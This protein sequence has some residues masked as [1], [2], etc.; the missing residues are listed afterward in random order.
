MW[1]NGNSTT[2]QWICSIRSICAHFLFMEFRLKWIKNIP[3]KLLKCYL[4]QE[5]SSDPSLQSFNEKKVGNKVNESKDETKKKKKNALNTSIQTHTN[6]YKVYTF[7]PLQNR[8]RSMQSPLP[9]ANWP[10]S[11]HTGSSVYSKG[12]TLRSLFLSLQFLTASFQSHVCFSM[13]KYRPAG[14]RI[15]CKPYYQISKVWNPK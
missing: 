2:E 6:K 3:I 10:S 11:L 8:P 5:F 4:P 15:A 9:Q 7:S 13:S 1:A 12:F 14:H